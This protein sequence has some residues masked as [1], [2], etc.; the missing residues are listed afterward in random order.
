MARPFDKATRDEIRTREK[1]KKKSHSGGLALDVAA[2]IDTIHRV[3]FVA[4]RYPLESEREGFFDAHIVA[5]RYP[6]GAHMRVFQ[7]A[8]ISYSIIADALRAGVLG[9]VE[10]K[11]S[12]S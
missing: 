10:N 3:R 5:R 12:E 6:E 7:K 9:V 11:G 8:G 4:A 2:A 1:P